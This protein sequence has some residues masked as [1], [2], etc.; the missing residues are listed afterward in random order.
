MS[1]AANIRELEFWLKTPTKSISW[2]DHQDGE[3]VIASHFRI[4]DMLPL[5][6][7]PECVPSRR[8][9]LIFALVLQLQSLL[10]D[11]PEPYTPAE[12]ET[13]KES[14]L[15]WARE[16]WSEVLRIDQEMGLGVDYDTFIV[17]FMPPAFQREYQ[18]LVE[19]A[20]EKERVHRQRV[21]IRRVM[22]WSAIIG[23]LI[24]ALC[25]RDQSLGSVPLPYV[26]YV[27]IGLGVLLLLDF[28]VSW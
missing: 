23:G 22:T 1:D 15:N 21:K 10:A 25:F 5:L 9:S 11:S 24:L 18:R 6:D 8:D 2:I 28:R 12:A 19:V 3:W 27:L 20:T 14:L 4:R 7:S 17:P 26:G 13:A 16:N